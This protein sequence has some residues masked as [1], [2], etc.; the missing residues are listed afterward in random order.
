MWLTLNIYMKFKKEGMGTLLTKRASVEIVNGQYVIDGFKHKVYKVF[1]NGSDIK[2]H[3][4]KAI[5]LIS[6]M[7]GLGYYLIEF[8]RKRVTLGKD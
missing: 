4:S 7:F 3:E 1:A 6:Y 8:K 5:E 2:A